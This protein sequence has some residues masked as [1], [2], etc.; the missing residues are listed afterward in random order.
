[1]WFL[2]NKILRFKYHSIMYNYFLPRSHRNIYT[3]KSDYAKVSAIPHDTL[4]ITT[5]MPVI[6][7]A[8]TTRCL[9][10]GICLSSLL[11]L[12]ST[13]WPDKCG[14]SWLNEK[15]CIIIKMFLH[16]FIKSLL[17]RTNYMKYYFT[18]NYRGLINLIRIWGLKLYAI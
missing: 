12:I 13:A 5:D 11:S 7:Y 10:F 2:I 1:M 4:R 14:S 16:R 18:I 6:L 15:W 3:E 17:S 8:I 9:S